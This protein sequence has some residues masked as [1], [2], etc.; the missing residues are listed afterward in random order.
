MTGMCVSMY[1][2]TPIY[3]S[4]SKKSLAENLSPVTPVTRHLRRASRGGAWGASVGSEREADPTGPTRIRA[5]W[6]RHGPNS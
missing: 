2:L 6:P 3:A 1:T 4:C 5:E